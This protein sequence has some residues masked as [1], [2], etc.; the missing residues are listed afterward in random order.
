MKKTK[1]KKKRSFKRLL[2]KVLWFG[3]IFGLI[4]ILGLV[5]A[6]LLFYV[7]I[8]DTNKD[9]IEASS[10]ISWV[11]FTGLV[12]VCLMIGFVYAFRKSKKTLLRWSRKSVLV[13]IPFVII[14]TLSSVL[15]V[16]QSTK[17]QVQLNAIEGVSG[18]QGYV[19]GLSFKPETLLEITNKQRSKPLVLSQKLSN[20]AEAKCKDM[21]KN[22]YWDHNDKQGREP[23]YFM[24]QVDYSYEYAGENLAY[25]F[26]TES[27][28]IT[29]WMNSEGHRKNILD[30]NFT[31]VGFGTC[32][33][34]NYIGQGKQ[35]IVVQ[36]FGKPGVKP[37]AVQ[38]G[39]HNT[40]TPTYTPKPYVASVCTK[41]VI[42]HETEYIEVDYLY[43]GETREYS[44][45][46][47]GYKETCTADSTGYKPADYTSPPYNK[48]VYVG[49]KQKHT[50]SGSES[51]STMTYQQAYNN[52]S[53]QGVPGNS[54]AM[55]QCINAYLSQ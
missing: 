15:A 37:S 5:V 25:G 44:S 16:N 54:S 27:D 11:T 24:D 53:A 52:C 32:V 55:Q 28:T 7:F 20:S 12:V 38:Q 19:E 39:T 21:V 35:Y 18:N 3:L 46:W 17:N 34:G 26:R 2:L 30:V 1:S 8:A 33:S 42:P 31:E 43:V 41:T 49:T 51:Q 29:G 9:V 47:D 4:F 6:G 36:H 50:S 23:W 10:A 48:K 22:D 14:G 13:L 45:G 40:P